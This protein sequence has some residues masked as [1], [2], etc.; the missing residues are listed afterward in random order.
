MKGSV[1]LIFLCLLV[2]ATY[3]Q[4]SADSTKQLKIIIMNDNRNRPVLD[5]REYFWRSSCLDE[6]IFSR[7]LYFDL[8]KYKL[9][10]NIKDSVFNN[11][12]VS[13][14]L[15]FSESNKMDTIYTNQFFSRWIVKEQTFVS[16]DDF[17]K[18]MLYPLYL[19]N[20]NYMKKGEN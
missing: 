3:A 4:E 16:S 19:G 18:K 5:T 1:I 11:F 12:S 15:I 2:R 17:L 10:K 8:V 20:Y 14:A 13:A 6:V 7:S 9:S